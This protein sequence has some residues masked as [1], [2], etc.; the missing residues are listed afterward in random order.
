M[1]C[2]N[3]VL[4]AL[5]PLFVLY[6]SSMIISELSGNREISRIVLY[7]ALTVGTAFLFRISSSLISYRTFKCGANNVY[8]RMSKLYAFRYASMDY[9]HVEDNEVNELMH[10]IKAKQTAN[11]FGLLRLNSDIPMLFGKT[12]GLVASIVLLAGMFAP[13]PDGAFI[14]SP[15]V[16]ILLILA[17]VV[18][19]SV[20]QAFMQKRLNKL[21]QKSLNDLVKTQTLNQYYLN[22][23]INNSNSG[24]DVR[25]FGLQNSIMNTLI[26]AQAW[27]KGKWKRAGCETSAVT[28]VVG[29]FFVVLIYAVIGLRALS[30]MYNIGEI[31]RYVGAIGAFSVSATSFVGLFTSL[32]RNASYLPMLFDYLNLPTRK[33]HGTLKTDINQKIAY[34][35][36][37]HDVSFKYPGTDIYALKNVSIKFQQGKRLAVVGRNGSG[38]TTLVKLLCRLYDPTCGIITLNGVDIREYILDEYIKILSVVFQDFSLLHLPIG[39]N[40][41]VESDYD[42]ETVKEALKKTGFDSRLSELENGLDTAVYKGYDDSGVMFSGG[43][44]QKIALARA[45]YRN[46]PFVVL[47][48]PTAALDPPAEYEIYT[49]FDS[50][51]NGKTTVYISHRL[52]SCRFC[53][54]IAVFKDGELIQCGNHETLLADG[55]GEYF[56]LWTTQAEHY[57]EK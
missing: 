3:N 27:Y 7:V 44:A 50:I 53:D 34:E 39:Q 57:T 5:N 41:A 15:I 35:L 20:I 16:I 23:F 32:Y 33:Y 24:K 17:S 21:L 55:N 9:P 19:P 2:L 26:K 31:A 48:E 42:A 28:A 51:I 40:V 38:K 47:D 13:N 11:G 10:D 56:K 18:I 49:K 4:E 36:E 25:I 1:N 12:V 22:N 29:I 43:E 14:N 8:E 46:A 52:S 54:D 45:L 37:L 6:F 30:G